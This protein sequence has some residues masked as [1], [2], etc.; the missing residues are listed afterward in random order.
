[1]IATRPFLTCVSLKFLTHVLWRDL[2]VV[3]H[4]WAS[5]TR[6]HNE[7]CESCDSWLI[8]AN[9]QV[10]TSS[11][12]LQVPT[13]NYLTQI[14]FAWVPVWPR[15]VSWEYPWVLVNTCLTWIRYEYLWVHRYRGTWPVSLGT[16]CLIPAQIQVWVLDLSWPAGTDPGYP[17]VHSWPALVHTGDTVDMDTTCSKFR[18]PVHAVYIYT[19]CTR[20]KAS[21]TNLSINVY[22]RRWVRLCLSWQLRSI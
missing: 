22:S 8:G 21:S 15:L 5:E 18:S 13:S 10:L 17:Q 16:R 11:R 2:R 3:T 6:S 9:P 20:C 14:C 19:A 7:S 12:Y 1:M 4:E